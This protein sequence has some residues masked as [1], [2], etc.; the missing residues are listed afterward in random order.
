MQDLTILTKEIILLTHLISLQ[1]LF[2]NGKESNHIVINMSF[3][4]TSQNPI[5]F[6]LIIYFIYDIPGRINYTYEEKPTLSY[7]CTL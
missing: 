7:H 2:I 6:Q 4:K 5:L 3:K 1:G